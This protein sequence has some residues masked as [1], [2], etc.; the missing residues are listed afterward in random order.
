[1]GLM[2]DKDHR[3]KLL[4]DEDILHAEFIGIHPCV[5]TASLRL[6]VRDLVQTVIPAMDHTMTTVNLP[7]GETA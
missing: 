4:I 2:N 1:M 6:R 7:Q 5:N 3:V